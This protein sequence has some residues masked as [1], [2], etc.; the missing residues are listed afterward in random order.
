MNATAPVIEGFWQWFDRTSRV[1]VGRCRSGGPGRL[2]R[3]VAGGGRSAA[4]WTRTASAFLLLYTPPAEDG[5]VDMVGE[6]TEPA[7]GEIGPTTGRTV[8]GDVDDTHRSSDLSVPHIMSSR[9]RV[10]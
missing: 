8:V 1:V 5:G 10:P 3:R 4:A 9:V 2:A 6:M 7:V